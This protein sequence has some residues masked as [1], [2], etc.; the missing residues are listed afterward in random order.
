M[1]NECFWCLAKIEGRWSSTPFFLASL[2]HEF[3]AMFQFI[4][5]EPNAKMHG[6]KNNSGPMHFA[7][8]EQET[9][10]PILCMWNIR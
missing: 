1:E 4:A 10:L 3:K 5:A 2:L 7:I 6:K 9:L 8:Y